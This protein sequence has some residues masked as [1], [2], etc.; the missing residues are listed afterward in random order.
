MSRERR[1]HR[2]V[3]DVSEIRGSDSCLH[4]REMQEAVRQ[5]DVKGQ[6]AAASL[7]K[8]KEEMGVNIQEKV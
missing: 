6:K 4:V 8:G 5:H 2:A 1:A 7:A 3:T